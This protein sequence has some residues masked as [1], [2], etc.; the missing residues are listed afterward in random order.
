MG[1][2]RHQ[3]EL[4]PWKGVGEVTRIQGRNPEV[5]KYGRKWWRG[6]GGQSPASRVGVL[7]EGSRGRGGDRVSGKQ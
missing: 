6:R 7:W 4:E 1:W 2:A 3:V 5:K